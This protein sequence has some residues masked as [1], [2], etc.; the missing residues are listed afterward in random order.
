MLLARREEVGARDHAGIAAVLVED[1]EVAVAGGGH[2]LA[3]VVDG[4]VHAEAQDLVGRQHLGA[5]RDGHGDEACCCIGVIRRRDD[6]AAVCRCCLLHDMAHLGAVA[7]DEKADARFDGEALGLVAVRDEH[8]VA[9]LDEALHHLRGGADAHV[10]PGHFPL[11]VAEHE[12]ALER[13]DDVGILRLRIAHDQ[14]VEDVHV[15]VGDILDGDDAEHLLL[16]VRDAEGIDL[17]RAHRVPGSEQRHLG[18][19]A[20]HLLVGDVLDLRT[21]AR[22]QRRLLEAEVIE[23]E[24]GLAVHGSG[25][26]CFVVCISE[27]VLEVGVGDCG[28]DAVR[29]RMEVADYIDLA[30]GLGFGHVRDSLSS[31]AERVGRWHML[32]PALLLSRRHMIQG[33][34]YV[35]APLLAPT[36]RE[37]VGV[38]PKWMRKDQLS[39]LVHAE[40]ASVKGLRQQ[41][42]GRD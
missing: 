8:D 33:S 11:G 24:G 20:G 16:V 28:T 38:R 10:A 39:Q 29:I 40:R 41:A 14:R 34:V 21:H 27:L 1:R 12:L 6:G 19:D 25:A 32:S 15:R 36:A 3:G 30:D 18:V 7:D 22:D 31:C 23:H 26:A 35:C 17:A 5:D 4:R 13:F 42:S 37:R 9:R 2:C